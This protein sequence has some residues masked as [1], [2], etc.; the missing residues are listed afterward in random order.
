M[1]SHKHI[2]I[3]QHYI[4]FYDRVEPI[5][6][7]ALLN[8]LVPLPVNVSRSY[9]PYLIVQRTDYCDKTIQLIESFL[10]REL[11]LSINDVVY[12]TRFGLRFRRDGWIRRQVG[13]ALMMMCVLI[14]GILALLGYQES[15]HLSLSITHVE[16]QLDA[17]HRYHQSIMDR[18]QVGLNHISRVSRKGLMGRVHFTPTQIS[19]WGI[20]QNQLFR[21]TESL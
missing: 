21:S 13:Y 8:Q 4:Y 16:N 10:Q 20:S 11:S 9:V 15:V 18:N 19:Y 12:R 6:I 5:P 17:Y 14:I 7:F 2:V 1:N 3:D